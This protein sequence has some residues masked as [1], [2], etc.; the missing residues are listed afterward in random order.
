MKKLL[1]ALI[2]T[3][4][5][6]SCKTQ[7][8]I[9]TPETYDREIITFGSGGGFTGKIKKYSILRNGQVFRNSDSPNG[10]D[11]S[12]EMS[13]LDEAVVDQ[14]FLNFTNLKLVEIQLDDPGNMTNFINYQENGNTH[15][16]RWGGK[17]EE[18]P[19]SVKTYYKILNQLVSKNKGIIK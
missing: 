11:A 1:I 14:L 5:F 4:P 15:R 12:G 18:V 13:S 9:Y 6:L 7:K 17:N 2:L 16:I 3:L 10:G 8:K 19:K